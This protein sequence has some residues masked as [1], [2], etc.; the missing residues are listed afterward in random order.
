LDILKQKLVTAPILV[1]PYWKKE[2][3]VHID[4]SSIIALGAVLDFPGEEG[5]DHPIAFSSRKLLTT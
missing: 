2:F 5:L 4:A 1:F 3:H